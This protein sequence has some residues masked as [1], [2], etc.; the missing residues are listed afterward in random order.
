MPCQGLN[1]RFGEIGRM[2]PRPQAPWRKR[3]DG[4]KA[5]TQAPGAEAVGERVLARRQAAASRG[6]RQQRGFAPAWI[7][8]ETP[9]VTRPL[10]RAARR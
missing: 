10:C 4:A 9:M 2:G 6:R 1:G 7:W 8:R 5:L 3:A